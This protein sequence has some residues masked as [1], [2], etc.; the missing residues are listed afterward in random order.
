MDS[1][2]GHECYQ[3]VRQGVRTRDFL[4]QFDPRNELVIPR[5]DFYRGLATAGLVLTPV[6]MDTLMEV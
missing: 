2:K 4:K 5:A 3:M 6:E 1:S